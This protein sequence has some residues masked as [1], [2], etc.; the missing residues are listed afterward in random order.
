MELRAVRSKSTENVGLIVIIDGDDQGVAGRKRSLHQACSDR[1]VAPPGDGDCVLVC[2]PTWNIETWLA[3]LQGEVV[4]ETRRD[5]PRLDRPRDCEPHVQALATMC[6][7]TTSTA[8]FP[9]SL[10]DTCTQ[11]RRIFE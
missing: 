1:E 5:Y 9:P 4:D 11:Y 7:A 2:V 3:F 10:E 8:E 6:R